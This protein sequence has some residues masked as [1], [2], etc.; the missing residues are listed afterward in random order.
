MSTIWDLLSRKLIRGC[1]GTGGG[2]LGA[3][4][5]V[6]GVWASSRAMRIVLSSLRS[7]LWSFS[8]IQEAVRVVVT[9]GVTVARV[10]APYAGG[11]P[12]SSPRGRPIRGSGAAA[13][14]KS[15]VPSSRRGT[16]PLTVILSL[17]A[18]GNIAKASGFYSSMVSRPLPSAFAQCQNEMARIP[19]AVEGKGAEPEGEGSEDSYIKVPSAGTV[20][21]EVP[22]IAAGRTPPQKETGNGSG[23]KVLQIPGSSGVALSRS[24]LATAALLGTQATAALSGAAWIAVRGQASRASPLEWKVSGSVP[25]GTAEPKRTTIP[26]E[27]MQS[28][29]GMELPELQPMREGRG[30]MASTAEGTATTGTGIRIPAAAEV[31]GN[32]LPRVSTLTGITRISGKGRMLQDAG[33]ITQARIQEGEGAPAGYGFEGLKF[34]QEKTRLGWAAFSPLAAAIDRTEFRKAAGI[35]RPIFGAVSP[36]LFALSVPSIALGLPGRKRILPPASRVVPSKQIADGQVEVSGLPSASPLL[37]SELPGPWKE[38]PL[39]ALNLAAVA[40]EVRSSIIA[41]QLALPHGR[42]ARSGINEGYEATTERLPVPTE[43]EEPQVYPMQREMRVSVTVDGDEDLLELQRKI[44]R[45]LEDEMRR[46]YG[47]G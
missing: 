25:A 7:I 26:S 6:A 36:A 32:K 9:G 5:V 21:G 31:T 39:S 18:A 40:E 15:R 23:R 47:E 8:S 30:G 29:T 43:L 42:E 33:G 22:A 2:T 27:G 3:H 20:I 35:W 41:P 10:S 4:L 13:P 17:S 28:P 38:M 34:Q 46:H 45:I 11:V 44:S 16:V 1:A 14:R 12:W 19:V 37:G 24:F